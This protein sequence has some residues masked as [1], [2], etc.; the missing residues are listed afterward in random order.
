MEAVEAGSGRA[1][2]V[3]GEQGIGKTR[4]AQ[5]SL[6][7]ARRRGWLVL[8]GRG[9]ALHATVPYGPVI[10][11]FGRAR[12]EL[13]EAQRATATAALPALARILDGL[14]LDEPPGAA[15]PAADKARLFE[16]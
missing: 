5:E 3:A 6:A 8:E 11:S 2:V 9:L 12:R 10:E 15:G 14:D 7:E 16:H 4:F 1:V 13:D